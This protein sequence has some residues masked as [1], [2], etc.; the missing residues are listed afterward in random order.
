[1]GQTESERAFAAAAS[2]PEAQRVAHDLHVGCRIHGEPS[3]RDSNSHGQQP[4]RMRPT[5]RGDN[6]ASNRA[7]GG[8]APSRRRA[9]PDDLNVLPT[10][11]TSELGREID[12]GSLYGSR[13]SR[14]SDARY[15]GTFG[16]QR[17]QTAQRSERWCSN[18]DAVACDGVLEHFSPVHAYAS[19]QRFE[20]SG[21]GAT[22]WRRVGVPRAPRARSTTRDAIPGSSLE[23]TRLAALEARSPPLKSNPTTT[24]LHGSSSMARDAPLPPE[25]LFYL[26]PSTLG[27]PS[28]A[29]LPSVSLRMNGPTI[30]TGVSP[31]RLRGDSTSPPRLSPLSHRSLTSLSARSLAA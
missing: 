25:H 29:R 30:I 17:R 12:G 27:L 18:L 15:V 26:T 24:I 23:R 8:G 6:R 13:G 14:S 2:R 9:A 4:H 16:T 20:S 11:I 7:G 19:H 21:A 1:M 10:S 31:N 5:P 28:S 22:V 3:Q